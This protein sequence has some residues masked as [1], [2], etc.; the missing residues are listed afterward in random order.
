M[1]RVSRA[2]FEIG[3]AI[4]LICWYFML[5]IWV[6]QQCIMG[7]MMTR[8]FT[9]IPS[10]KLK[11]H[12]MLPHLPH[13]DCLLRRA[14]FL[15][16]GLLRVFLSLGAIPTIPM[17]CVEPSPFLLGH[18]SALN[19]IP[20]WPRTYW[21]APLSTSY[22]SKSKSIQPSTISSW[23][24]ENNQQ[25]LVCWYPSSFQTAWKSIVQH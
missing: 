15:L 9:G 14:A 21:N 10:H 1:V 18:T 4:S 13:S 22:S 11:L 17:G 16:L 12:T 25:R 24:H 7:K 3:V 2:Y 6:Y 19:L 5:L 8:K 23:T 20:G